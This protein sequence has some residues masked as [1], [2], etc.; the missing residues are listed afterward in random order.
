MLSSWISKVQIIWVPKNFGSKTF[1]VQND[2]YSRTII[3]SK[4]LGK[5][6]WPFTHFFLHL[7]DS[8]LTP[9]RQ[10]PDTLKMPFKHTPDT[11]QIPIRCLPDIPRAFPSDKSFF[12]V[13]VLVTWRNQNQ[14]LLCSIKV[15]SNLQVYSGVWQKL[16][17]GSG[18][19]GNVERLAQICA[20]LV[21]E[22]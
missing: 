18:F 12:L 13:L 4:I 20:T 21:L 8:F 10:L 14:L 17:V 7:S 1:L 15:E 11:F 22:S 5:K 19:R 9:S 16:S 3:G 6:M 2:I